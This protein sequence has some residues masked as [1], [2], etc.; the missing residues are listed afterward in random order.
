MAATKRSI[1]AGTAE[2]GAS[3][4]REPAGQP[5]ELGGVGPHRGGELGKEVGLAEARV[6]R[7]VEDEMGGRTGGPS[8]S[9]SWLGGEPRPHRS[10]GYVSKR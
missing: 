6:G 9:G 2:D 10:H 1:T 8:A 3:G 7:H 5:V 4:L